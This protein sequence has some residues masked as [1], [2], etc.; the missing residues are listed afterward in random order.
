MRNRF[1]NNDKVFV[2]G[3]GEN[4]GKFYRNIPAII[5]ERDPF[6]QDY[7]IKFKDSTEDWVQEKYLRK[8]YERIKNTKK[9]RKT[10]KRS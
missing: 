7:L 5:I 8:P 3:Y 6:Y 9:E 2:Y 1:K 4:D 10:E